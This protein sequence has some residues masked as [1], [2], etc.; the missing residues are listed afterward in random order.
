MVRFQLKVKEV[1]GM[2]GNDDQG[3]KTGARA[4]LEAIYE[5]E[6]MATNGDE[7][8]DS[9]RL[10]VAA[11]LKNGTYGSELEDRFMWAKAIAVQNFIRSI[12]Q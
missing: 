5:L 4:F 2:S 3:M 6:Q 12:T 1:L 9:I 7:Y 8:C 10:E 11:A